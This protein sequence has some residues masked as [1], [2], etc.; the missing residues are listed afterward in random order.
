MIEKKIHKYLSVNK[1]GILQKAYITLF[2]N[3]LLC[4]QFHALM[5]F[6]RLYVEFLAAY[7]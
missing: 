7:P 6:Y 1:Y 2:T 3:L 4:M 5:H